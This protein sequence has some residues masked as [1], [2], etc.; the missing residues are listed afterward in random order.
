MIQFLLSVI[1][2]TTL[3]L[4]VFFFTIEAGVGGS[5]NWS[6]ANSLSP[7]PVLINCR[8]VT[9]Y[10]RNRAGLL[11]PSSSD[12]HPTGLPQ[13]A[14]HSLTR[15]VLPKPAGA[16]MRVNFRLA[17]SPSFNR[18]I[19]PGRGR[20]LLSNWRNVEF[21]EEQGIRQ[22]E[23]KYTTLG[24]GGGKNERGKRMELRNPGWKIGEQDC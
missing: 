17:A 7:I 10:E 21:G 13:S 8:A 23:I 4:G 19:R 14:I 22:T 2:M 15:V 3:P 16:G 24:I 11:S 9:R 5:R 12:N 6:A 20:Q 1:L 18:A